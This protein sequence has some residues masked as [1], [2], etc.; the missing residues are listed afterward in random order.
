MVTRDSFKNTQ[1]YDNEDYLDMVVQFCNT[2][3]DSN[4]SDLTEREVVKRISQIQDIKYSDNLSSNQLAGFL[5]GQNGVGESICEININRDLVNKLSAVEVKAAIY[6][7]LIHAVSQHTVELKDG[8]RNFNGLNNLDMPGLDEVMTEFYMTELLKYE[9]LSLDEKYYVFSKHSFL[10]SESVSYEG[11]SYESIAHLGAIYSIIYGNDIA[12]GKFRNYWKFASH[13]HSDLKNLFSQSD[14]L[15]SSLDHQM[16]DAFINNSRDKIIE[17]YKISLNVFKNHILS[18]A[19]FDLY[20]YLA[21]SKKIAGLL[22]RESSAYQDLRM[23]Q[24]LEDVI[25]EM[26]TEVL[27]RFL[28]EKYQELDGNQVELVNYLQAIK[29]IRDNIETLNAEDL[30]KITIGNA[31]FREV[32]TL[33]IKA[34][35]GNFIAP[36]MNRERIEAKYVPFVDYD[37]EYCAEYIDQIATLLYPH[38]IDFVIKNGE[39]LDP[40]QNFSPVEIRNNDGLFNFGVLKKGSDE[41]ALSQ[42]ST[43]SKRR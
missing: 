7:E 32:D 26:D 6:H 23:V 17:S 29:I 24:E 34:P 28:P 5:H 35:N 22:P 13:L 38:R 25:T 36:S 31:R 3:L 30:Q 39:L 14:Y 1:L 27:K 12:N 9:G 11:T 20:D 8:K 41:E 4:I 10:Y 43:T 21:Q 33:V 18:E 37:F 40:L 16:E 19:H 42:T 2:F 15:L